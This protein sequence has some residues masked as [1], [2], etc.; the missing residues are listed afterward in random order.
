[1]KTKKK[2]SHYTN[3]NLHHRIFEQLLIDYGMPVVQ[4]EFRF[5]PTRQ[6]RFDFAFPGLKFA[7]EVEG[8][9]FTGQAHSSIS[10]ILRD[11]EKYNEAAKLGWTIYRVIPANLNKKE[12]IEDIKIIYLLRSNLYQNG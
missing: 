11:I 7:I 2:K 5:H 12:T 3:N 4:K 8:G 1:M 9:V 6:W 10:G